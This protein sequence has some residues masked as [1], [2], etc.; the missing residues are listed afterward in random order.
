M[1]LLLTVLAFC[2]ALPSIYAQNTEDALT[3]SRDS[4]KEEIVAYIKSNMEKSSIEFEKENYLRSILYNHK[5]LGLAKKIGDSLLLAIS[6]SY[7]ANDYLK[8]DNIEQAR[9]YI[10]QNINMAESMNDTVLINAAKIDLA[11][12]YLEEKRY[13]EFIQLNKEVIAIARQTNDSYRLITSNLNIAEA[14]LFKLEMADEARAYIDSLRIYN[15]QETSE[16]LKIPE[17]D[18]HYLEGQYAFLKKD[19][20]EAKKNFGFV[21]DNYKDTH[22]L[23]YLLDSYSG[24][25]HSL[26]QLGE[27][28]EAYAS[29][30]VIDSLFEN[31]LK[32]VIEESNTILKHRIKIENIEEEI[33]HTEL[34]S[35]I[36]SA[37]AE[38]NKILLLTTVVIVIVLLLVLLFFIYERNKRT[39]LLQ[40][41]QTKNEEYLEAKDKSEEMARLKTKFLSTIS[42]ELRTPLYGI[43]GLSDYLFQAPQLALYEK[44]LQS[45]KFSANYLLSLV[46]DV[47]TLN[48]IESGTGIE[49]EHKAFNI[50]ELIEDIC[51]S[52]K[53]MKE[54]NSNNLTIEI[55]EEIPKIVVGDKIKLSQI[56]INLIGNALKFTKNGEVKIVVN[57]IEKDKKWVTLKF[58]IQDDGIGISET[59]KKEIFK[60]FANLKKTSKFA[61]T[62]LGLSIVTKLLHE[63]HS[64]IHLISTIGAGSNFYFELKL[65]TPHQFEKNLEPSLSSTQDTRLSGKKILIIDDNHI[66]QLVTKKYVEKYGVIAKSVDTAIEGIELLKTEFFDLVLMDLNMPKI[67]GLKATSIIRTFNTQIKII[68][69]SATEVQ[70]LRAATKGY[71]INDV[72]SKPHKTQDL[73]ELLLKHLTE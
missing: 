32:S 62:G 20:K 3:I 71:D 25:I 51:N 46:N 38:K 31:K 70:E 23:E 68:I 72:L 10:D 49:I 54:R 12:I 30:K 6:R 50:T 45:L 36:V 61:G 19:F 16:D 66:N 47:L 37:K 8:L 22:K 57:L 42:H 56:L 21:L 65:E 11:N 55:A 14:Y 44:E 9:Y 27:Y 60:E 58:E 53:F 5:N 7:I 41:L 48:K 59:E 28:E 39:V 40:Q 18:F 67:N 63:M 29:F 34:Q 64:E 52:L 17:E 15:A 69:L 43:I 26:A 35:K 33:E 73:Y 13:E 24:Y 2:M 1:K 4:T